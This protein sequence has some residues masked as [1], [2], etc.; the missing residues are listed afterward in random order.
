MIEEKVEAKIEKEEEMARLV[1]RPVV[2]GPPKNQGVI[3]HFFARETHMA[4]K[5][6]EESQERRRQKGPNWY[7]EL[8]K[9]P[10]E[11]KIARANLKRMQAHN[12][13]VAA[14]EREKKAAKK[15]AEVERLKKKDDKD[16]K[17]AQRLYNRYYK[18]EFARK[19]SGKNAKR[20]RVIRM[21]N[22]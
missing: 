21:T 15:K 4:R 20:Q 10:E 11:L 16:K 3:T 13:A 18:D 6:L 17:A 22:K 5:K 14:T 8:K 9:S 1:K 19:E 12:R 2:S 7:S